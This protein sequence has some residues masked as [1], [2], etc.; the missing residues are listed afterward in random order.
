MAR[1]LDLSASTR[2]ASDSE[3]PAG[4]CRCGY[5]GAGRAVGSGEAGKGPAASRDDLRAH[6][7]LSVARRGALGEGDGPA[8][9]RPGADHRLESSVSG[10]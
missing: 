10:A 5:R 7:C 8:P 1:T 3:S 4:R 6:P 2:S 9:V